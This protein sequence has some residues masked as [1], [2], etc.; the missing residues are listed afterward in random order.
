M[1]VKNVIPTPNKIHQVIIF[2]FKC[3]LFFLSRQ[4]H[5]P[6]TSRAWRCGGIWKTSARNWSP[7]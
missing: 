1:S 3:L 5:L 6:L 2:C 7:I 4:L